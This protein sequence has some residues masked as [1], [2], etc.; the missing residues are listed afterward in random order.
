MV[1]YG[2]INNDD[3]GTQPVTPNNA[4]SCLHSINSRLVFLAAVAFVAGLAFFSHGPIVSKRN[5]ADVQLVQT[6]MLLGTRGTVRIG[7]EAQK[8]PFPYVDRSEYNAL[9]ASDIVN[10]ELFDPSLR[11]NSSS[12]GLLTVPFPTG[13]FWTNL[14]LTKSTSDQGFSYPIMAYPYSYRWSSLKVQVSYPPLRR[15]MDPISI[16]DIFNPD[17]TLD[18][19]ESTKSRH[20]TAFDPLSVTLR[21]STTTTE[22]A[23][24][25][26]ET[27][28]VQGSPYVTMAYEK[29]TPSLTA[30]SIF[31]SFSCGA[32]TRRCT[33]SASSSSGSDALS[34]VTLQGT[35][36]RITTQEN[37]TWLLFASDTISLSY[38]QIHKTTVTSDQPFSGV[39]RLVL[40]PPKLDYSQPHYTS[41]F[42][43]VYPSVNISTNV[44]ERLAC[45]ANVYPMGGK[46]TW[47]FGQK[48]R[49]VFQKEDVATVN[50]QFQ[51]QQ[52]SKHKSGCT[53]P[54]Q[55][56]ML[57]L[58]HH[59]QCLPAKSLKS[60]NYLGEDLIFRTIK[61]TMTPV[62]GNI[63]TYAE[64]LTT[65]EFDSASTL[66]NVASLDDNTKQ[67]ILDQVQNDM[68]RVLPTLDENVYGFGKQIARLAQLAHIASV[69]E[70]GSE[71]TTAKAEEEEDSLT[72]AIT[73]ILHRYLSA[74]LQGENKDKLLYDTNFGGIVSQN[75]LVDFMDDFGNGW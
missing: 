23:S 43:S 69:L 60:N 71:R 45:H 49:G 35:Q 63:W 57:A 4:R 61:G 42:P 6:K 36:F 26:W 37:L 28:L 24:A 22:D 41:Q 17:L 29:T 44:E 62:V 7:K 34:P 72:V 48:R 14:V 18:V 70:G 56:L 8:V 25:Y 9:H 65:I 19:L 1:S 64:P 40:L 15:L 73:K 68:S 74:F 50:F 52:M 51:T 46:V 53:D 5:H 3:N 27:Y 32:D 54:D 33:P 75:G 2:S 11:D 13:A 21:Y 12:G 66:Q 47:E 67:V 55:L 58:P 59:A 31:K 16:R 30:L 38:D 39:L 20:V 10:P